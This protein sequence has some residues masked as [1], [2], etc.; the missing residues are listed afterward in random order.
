MLPAL[1]AI[2]LLSACGRARAPAPPLPMDET[3]DQREDPSI[4]RVG[5]CGVFSGMALDQTLPLLEDRLRLSM[6]PAA[7]LEPR[8][9]PIMGA[10]E[11][12]EQESRIV[13]DNGDA[14]MVVMITELASQADGDEAARLRAISPPGTHIAEGTSD[15]GLRM[16][17]AEPDA[18][19]QSSPAIEVVRAFVTHTDG[20]LQQIVFL[21]N[22][23]AARG[24]DEACRYLPRRAL[25]SLKAGER[26]LQRGGS[27]RLPTGPEAEVLS[28]DLPDGWT[29]FTQNGPDFFVHRIVEVAPPGAPGVGGILYFGG[30]P[31][32]R[33]PQDAVEEPG[34]LYGAPIQ[35]LRSTE[36][37]QTSFEAVHAIGGPTDLVLATH[38]DVSL[39][40]SRQA[41]YTHAFFRAPDPAQL[42]GILAA[43]AA[44]RRE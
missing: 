17:T 10:P 37:G 18:L 31:N 11:P 8:A 9:A 2:V 21:V 25:A 34:T 44:A 30:H 39:V 13:L 40:V 35:W 38:D 28:I 27:W 23:E 14:R 33:R 36:A 24:D 3:G 20:T 32:A 41:W 6:P 43:L 26:A 16:V 7:H 5:P 1:A 29:V 12:D 19:D 4:T 22:P 42:D 15:T